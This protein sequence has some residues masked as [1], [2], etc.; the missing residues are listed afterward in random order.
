MKRLPSATLLVVL[1]FVLAAPARAVDRREL[2][3]GLRVFLVPQRSAPIVSVSVFLPVGRVHEPPR[4]AGATHF[5]E[6]MLFRATAKRPGGRSEREA[7]GAGARFSANTWQDFTRYEVVLPKERLDLALDLLS[8]ALLTAKFEPSEVEEERRVVIEEIAKRAADAELWTWEETDGLLY[9]PHPYGERIIGTV[10]GVRA[11][12]RDDLYDWYRER[13]RPDGSV[14]VIAGDFDEAA[15][16]EAVRKAFGA[17]RGEGPKPPAPPRP[18]AAFGHFQEMTVTRDGASPMIALSAG[19]PGFLHPDY[20][21][22]RFLAEL[23]RG[24]LDQRLVRETGGKVLSTAVWY[25]PRLLRNQLRIRLRV[26]SAADV[27]MARDA[28]L[29]LL[30]EFR[31]KDFPWGGLRNVAGNFR[32]R[33][34]LLREDLSTLATV[35]GRGALGG[36]YHEDGPPGYLAANDRYDRIAVADVVRAARRYLHP[37]NLRVTVLTSERIELPP[38]AGSRSDAPA[39]RFEPAPVPKRIPWDEVE[40]LAPISGGTSSRD[41]DATVTELPGGTRLVYLERNALPVVGVAIVFPAGSERDPVG[42]EGLAALTLRA[43]ERETKGDPSHSLRWRIFSAGDDRD[44]RVTRTTTRVAFTVP[45]EDFPEVLEAVTTILENPG[46]SPASI[47]SARAGLLARARRAKETVGTFAEQEFRR[48]I[49]GGDRLTHPVCGT[50]ESIRS[51]EPTDLRR[52]HAT[53]LALGRAVIAVVGDVSPRVARGTVTS[54]LRER[55]AAPHRPRDPLRGPSLPS[56]GRRVLSHPS[57]RGYLISGTSGPACSRKERAAAE[58][59]RLAVGWRVF[60]EMTDRLSIAYQAGSLY[61]DPVGPTPFGFYVGVQPERVETAEAALTAILDGARADGL[62]AA[63]HADAKGAWL[64]AWARSYLRSDRT[65]IRLATNLAR[66]W[67]VDAEEA[68]AERIRAVTRDDVNRLA[69]R[70]LA[71]DRRLTIV[72]R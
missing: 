44:F 53:H 31:K 68:L 5:M 10:R 29:G 26:A 46:F 24:W 12:S 67:P 6:H 30:A 70:L 66:G 59:L 37:S 9:R 17:W 20:L 11:M 32:A 61:L 50:P 43:L 55:P 40:P 36:Y 18:P 41:G 22:T 25:V 51:I 13:Y 69:R 45:R 4:L 58:L 28:L 71:P 42:K 39:G 23:M 57:G 14:L 47:R 19:M 49:L 27:P 8:D 34:L 15:A 16:F 63:L 56:A 21:S 35:I 38:A 7:W 2:P 65:A 62:D 1:F 64:G 72:V 52:F 48:G 60:T 3:N 54:M 33:E